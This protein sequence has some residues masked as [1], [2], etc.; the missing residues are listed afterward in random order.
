[1]VGNKTGRISRRR[2]AA[3]VSYDR[4][5][6]SS[7]VLTNTSSPASDTAHSVNTVLGAQPQAP[8]ASPRGTIITK[9]LNMSLRNQPQPQWGRCRCCAAAAAAAVADR[10]GAMKATE[11]T[12]PVRANG[13]GSA[14]LSLILSTGTFSVPLVGT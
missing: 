6:L 4:L 1:M 13:M 5:T 14:S 12:R 8:A 9:T 3:I 10:L 7:V 11:G 2:V